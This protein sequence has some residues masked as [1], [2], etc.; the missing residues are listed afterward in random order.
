MSNSRQIQ[1]P[2]VLGR[3]G[4]RNL[5]EEE[6]ARVKGGRNQTFAFTHVIS[7]DVTHD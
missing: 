6:V 7:D 1:E 4:A 2:R 3:A 5:S